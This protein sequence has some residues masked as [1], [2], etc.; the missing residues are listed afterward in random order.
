MN[1]L[2]RKAIRD[3]WRSKLRTIAIIAAI[4][5]SVGLGIG[6]VNATKD[7]FESFDKRLEETNYEDIDIHFEMTNV[8]MDRIRSMEGVDSAI[9]R[10]FIQTQTIFEGEKYKTHWVASPYYD[11][12]PYSRINGYQL[13]EGSYITSPTA[14]QCLVGNLFS[15]ENSLHPGEKVELL[16]SNRTLELEVSGIAASPEYIYVVGEE[17]WP[18]PSLLIPLFT[19]YELAAE[20]LDLEEDYYN[21]VLIKVED[22]YDAENVKKEVESILSDSGVRI[23]RSLL[24]TEE[25][26]YQFSR[27]DA[28][29]MGQM[30][31]T[32]GVIILVVTAVVIYNSLT[33][34]IASQRTYIG[35]M[36]AVGGRMS[37][38]LIHY[39][40][41]GFVMGL[42]GALIG[43]PIGALMSVGIMYA[44]A[45][46]IGLISPVYTIFWIYPLIFAGMGIL[47]STLGALFGAFKVVRIGPR[48][49][50][51]SQYQA[52]DY[53][54]KPIVERFFDKVA[55]RR[56]VLYRIPLRNLSRHRVRTLVTI[57]SLAASLLLVFAC[58]TLFMGFT[59]PLEKN[60]DEYE[61]WD[62]KADLLNPIPRETGS[63]RISSDRFS[64]TD[65][66]LMIDD[67]VSLNDEGE[68]KF[69]RVQAF[70]DDSHLRSF[71]VI[72]GENDPENGVLVGSILADDIGV[73]VGD[74][75][76]F[77]LG[78][79]K[80]TVE[81]TG[82]TGELM[83]DS[84]LMTMEQADS[85]LMANGTANSIILNMGGM[86]EEEV[87]GLLREEFSISSI[88]YTED[89]VN[90]I[91]SLLE[92]II[93]MFFIFIMFGIVAEVLFISTTVVLNIL[94][95]ETEFISLRA[96]GTKQGKIRRMIVG[97]TLIL[98]GGGLIVGL[99]LGVIVTKQAMAFIVKDLMYYVL[100]VPLEVYILTSLIAIVSA[101]GA[102]Y[103][104]ARWVTKSNL[105]ET[106]RNRLAR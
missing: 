24:G 55:Y 60:Y 14:R 99:P 43:I 16:Y 13:T 20:F 32:F 25:M 88:M 37:D 85:L 67:Y 77:V 82:I 23:T 96:I 52:Q 15:R 28:R 75:V 4:S 54:R 92:G 100:E 17:G 93:A 34:L 62:L 44:Y 71:H 66:E 86:D 65:A 61:K 21:E 56:P 40:L 64:G 57:V 26:D 101:I 5:L 3:L 91:E 74:E 90:G 83:D 94:D 95:R 87:E 59:Q 98:L 27:T 41:F 102:A 11:E 39:T 81:V 51:H 30:G 49:A 35:V 80:T 45:Q 78:N 6:L 89:V 10:I 103:I 53:S 72:E 70:N 84:I 63:E 79:R 58:L 47:I 19:T 42:V 2:V 7:A 104:S 73:D 22:G 29:A 76:E 38:I 50:L 69:V 33:R 31:W 105:A 97:E 8:S 68:M 9:G 46:V 12:E 36:E 1:I 48:E 106:I 18:E